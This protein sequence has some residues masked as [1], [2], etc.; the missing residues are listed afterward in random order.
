MDQRKIPVNI[1]IN[2]FR[3]IKNPL[4]LILSCKE[5]RNVANNS[6]AKAEWIISN[7]GKAH[8]L[9]H[10]VKLG[11]FF[12]D[13][14]TAQ[15]LIT[16]GAVLSRY[17]VQRLLLH[18]G[19][20]DP[21]LIGLKIT[22][23]VGQIDPNRI[24]SLQQKIRAPWASD[25]QLSVFAY[26]LTMA[27]NQFETIEWVRPDVKAITE[28]LM[29]L[30]E[31]KFQLNYN[32]IIKIL[33]LFEDRLEDIGET[34]MESFMYIKQDTRE[35]FSDLCLIESL[36]PHHNSNKYQVWDFLYVFVQNNPEIAFNKVLNHY[37]KKNEN[38]IKESEIPKLSLS[39]NFY[40]W[41]IKTFG[42][43][44]QNTKLCFEDILKAR[45]GIDK[46]LQQ[47]TNGDIPPG[48]NQHEFHAICNIYKVYCNTSNFYLPSH[49][50]MISQCT[51]QEILAPLFKYYL[52]DLFNVEKTFELPMQV[53]DDSDNNYNHIFPKST[54]KKR[55]KRLLKEWN[56]ALYDISAHNN[57]QF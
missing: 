16:K 13:L 30:V 57:T 40:D 39:S 14:P 36:K 51:S 4:N 8:A 12:I 55:K 49:L 35:N 25:I 45:I 37:L 42:S 7:H 56:Q 44:A 43:D 29:E 17:F 23:N 50:V 22:H 9:F 27:Q 15:A 34:L 41:I 33:Y 28:R 19:S 3:Y 5:W 1:K 38:L 6:E 54:K 46:Q 10:A 11:P 52:P 48:I 47:N 2:I 53:F 21:T 26:F 32:V 20:Y 18:Y 24:K 31:L